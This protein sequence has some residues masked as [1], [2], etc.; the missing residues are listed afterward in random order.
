VRSL[1]IEVQSYKEDNERL[2][3]EQNQINAQV[4]Q[5]LNQ[6]HRETKK[7]SCSRH[8]EGG[9][10]HERRDNY[11]GASYSRSAS[12]THRQH[13]PPHSTRKFYASEDS[14]SSLEVSPIR[15]QRRR[16]ELDNLQG[17]LRKLRPPSFD[18][19]REKEDDVEA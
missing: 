15:H 4:M 17:E 7:G 12:R 11:K 16:H 10:Q 6:L 2:M 18:G 9:R 19:E 5:S 13:S 14:I 8:E 3:K 1:K